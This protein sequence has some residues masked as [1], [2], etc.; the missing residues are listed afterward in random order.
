MIQNRLL[1]KPHL[2]LSNISVRYFKIY[3]SLKAGVLKLN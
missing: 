1:E 2:C 3:V